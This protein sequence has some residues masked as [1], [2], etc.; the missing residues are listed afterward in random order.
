MRGM[1]VATSV[2]IILCS[3]AGPVQAQ[4][5]DA[6]TKDCRDY[7]RACVQAHSQGACKSELDICLKHCRQK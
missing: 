1:I 4:K 3:A 2:L 7:H 6:C 5:V